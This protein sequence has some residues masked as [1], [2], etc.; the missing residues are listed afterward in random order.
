MVPATRLVRGTVNEPR[1]RPKPGVAADL[2][3]D[4]LI[5]TDVDGVCRFASAVGATTFG[6]HSDA[7]VGELYGVFVHPD[8][9]I[10]DDINR[11]RCVSEPDVGVVGVHRLRCGDGSYRWIEAH[12][13][14][15]AA[16]GETLVATSV[17]D[18]SVRAQRETDLRQRASTDPLTGVANR[19]VFMERLGHALRSLALPDALVAVLFM[20]L[21][22]FKRVNDVHGHG[23]GDAVLTQIAQRAAALLGPTDTLARLGGDEFAIIVESASTD[24]VVAFAQQLVDVGRRPFHVGGKTCICTA[25]VGVAVTSDVERPAALL[26]H[27]ADV[28][29]YAAKSRGRDRVELFRTDTRPPSPALSI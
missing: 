13:R 11:R 17:R 10:L 2:C 23:G 12:S 9:V 20:D 24:G 4:L 1:D 26:L 15:S 25:S 28:A 19:T 27:Q 29:L 21:D 5:V 16:G 7:L 18:I 6:W 8:D 14:S 3:P 22:G